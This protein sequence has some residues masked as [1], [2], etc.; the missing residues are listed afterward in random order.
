M[1]KQWN[2]VPLAVII[3]TILSAPAYADGLEVEANNLQVSADNWVDVT[4]NAPGVSDTGI[5]NNASLSSGAFDDARGVVHSNVAA[6]FYNQGSNQAS[7][8]TRAEGNLDEAASVRAGSA[9]ASSG[10]NLSMKKDFGG[11]NDN[12]ATLEG[13]FKD[14]KGIIGTNFAAGVSNL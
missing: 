9:Q 13:A 2:K 5:T 6:G 3:G 1:E 12:S 10:E 14:A 8:G 7:M 4:F 11:D